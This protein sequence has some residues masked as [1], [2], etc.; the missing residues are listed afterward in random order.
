MDGG[1]YA[2]TSAASGGGL[3]ARDHDR[4][5]AP[6]RRILDA[7][8]AMLAH[9]EAFLEGGRLVDPHEEHLFLPGLYIRQVT[10]AKGSLVITMKHATGHPWFCLRGHLR[11]R[12]LA[13][14]EVHEVRG[15]DRGVTR[16]GT[17][18]A[19]LAIEETVFV[20]VHPN[21]DDCRDL[22]ELERRLIV[23]QELPGAGGRTAG[24]LYREE[25]IQ[26]QGGHD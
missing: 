16:A 2:S 17:Q 10:N 8:A 9:P 11:V 13:T 24:E 3:A 4:L 22:A 20:T 6:E 12:D 23:R 1:V 21:P 26:L 5:G 7:Q 25:L 15:G 14:G 19:I 18:R